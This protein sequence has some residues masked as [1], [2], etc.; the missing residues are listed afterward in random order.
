[1]NA[2]FR[3]IKSRFKR[4][5]LWNKLAAIGSLASII[6]LA[7]VIIALIGSFFAAPDVQGFAYSHGFTWGPQT[8][9][10]HSDVLRVSNPM[11]RNASVV[12]IVVWNC[13][14]TPIESDSVSKDLPITIQAPTGLRFILASELSRSRDELRFE[15]EVHDKTVEVAMISDTAFEP[16]D[17]IALMLTVE[18][19]EEVPLSTHYDLVADIKGLSNEVHEVHYS[20]VASVAGAIGQASLGYS[21]SLMAAFIGFLIAS[22]CLKRVKSSVRG[23]TSKLKGWGTAFAAMIPL[24]IVVNFSLSAFFAGQLYRGIQYPSWYSDTEFSQTYD[25]SKNQLR[26]PVSQLW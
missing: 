3:K 5:T 9:S 2:S 7:Y 16:G 6:A 20:S 13:G 23:E 21:M 12:R 19:D 24:L 18:S 8:A 4:L 14:L 22:W 15:Q 10:I 1:M 25:P 17:G 11:P 26:K